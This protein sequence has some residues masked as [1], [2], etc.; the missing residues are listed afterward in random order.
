MSE[1]NVTPLVDVV[2]VLLIIFMVAAPMLT[3]GVPLD[4][5]K[6]DARSLP[7]EQEQPLT[8]NVDATGQ[9]F[10][11]KTPVAD[12]ELIPRLRAIAAERTSKRIYMRADRMLDYGRV[13][14][15]MGALSAGG[16]DQV[17]L[18]TDQAPREQGN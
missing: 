8:V 10:I 1:I 15:V 13:M 11:Q 5:P 2:M 18:V 14:Q 12:G 16:F 9:I 4:L 7:S 17:A 3:V 6:T